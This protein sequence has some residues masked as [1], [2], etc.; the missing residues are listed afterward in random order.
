MA[1]FTQCIAKYP[2]NELAPSAQWWVADYYYQN[3][4]FKNAEL[5]FQLLFQNWPS[6]EF[7]YQARMMAGRSAVGRAGW[8]DAIRFFTMLTG[9]TNCPADLR[10]QAMNAYGD[11]LISQ[12]ST[13]KT[14]DLQEA[15]KVFNTLCQSS[16]TN[17]EVDYAWGRLASCYLQWAQLSGQKESLTNAIAAFQKVIHSPRASTTARA[18]AKVSLGVVLEGQAQQKAGEE[19]V[20]LFK[21]ALANYLAVFYDEDGKPDV[22]WIKEAGLNAGRVAEK[23]QWWAK[24][25]NVYNRLKEMLP[26]QS[27][28]FDSRIRKA[29]E[30]L[31][32]AKNP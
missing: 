8:I 10:G 14:A 24:A 32:T 11:V 27:A 25:I 15:I 1:L 23:L 6:S 18:I 17:A 20:S 2:T 22:F 31:P 21:E 3:G 30:H 19:Q 9:D 5:N 4:D 26:Q 12:T 16:S 13:N 29:E 7:N 28:F